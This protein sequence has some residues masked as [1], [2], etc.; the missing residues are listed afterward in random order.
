MNVEARG[1]LV[2]SDEKTLPQ[3]SLAFV[4]Q[5]FAL[6]ILRQGCASTQTQVVQLGKQ[7]RHHCSSVSPYRAQSFNQ[8]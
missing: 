6:T 1:L 8:W 7:R 3:Q 2:L 5:G 4:R